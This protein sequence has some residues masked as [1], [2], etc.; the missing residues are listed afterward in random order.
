MRNWKIWLVI[1]GIPLLLLLLVEH[2]AG[3]PFGPTNNVKKSFGWKKVFVVK[4]FYIPSG[5]IDNFHLTY[6]DK[7]NF[8]PLKAKRELESMHLEN[9]SLS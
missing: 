6:R 5:N 2:V 1:L 9:V 8:V 4:C 7:V 3:A